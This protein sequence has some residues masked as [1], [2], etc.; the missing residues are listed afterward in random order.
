M[1][2]FEDF[3]AGTRFVFKPVT[4]TTEDIVAFAAEFDPQPMHL[5]EEAGKASI[6]GGLAASGWHTSAIMMRM[7]CDSYIHETA[8]EGSPGVNSMEWKKPVIA[9]DTLSGTCTVIEAR[10]SRSRPGIGIV[11]L[12]GEVIN[13]RG[14]T[15][16]I[17]DYANMI[18]CKPAGSDA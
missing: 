14:E 1:L 6:L 5:S 13:Q 4:V 16:A 10:T 17:C 11:Q 15:V 2:H 12:R 18:R 3:P 7:L 9:G 8:S